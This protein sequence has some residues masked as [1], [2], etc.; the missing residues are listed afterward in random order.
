MLNYID[1]HTIQILKILMQ[2]AGSERMKHTTTR[3]GFGIRLM[4]IWMKASHTGKMISSYILKRNAQLER[5]FRMV[6]Y[7]M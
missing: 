2:R 1:I 4:R 3:D 7:A 5:K 6:R